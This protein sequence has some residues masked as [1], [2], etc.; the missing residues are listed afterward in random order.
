MEVRVNPNRVL[1]SREAQQEKEI[2]CCVLA[3]ILSIFIGVFRIIGVDSQTYQA[4]AHFWV[5]GLF[6]AGYTNRTSDIFSA[7]NS[8]Y[9]YPYLLWMAWILTGLEAVCFI[10]TRVFD[11]PLPSYRG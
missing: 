6:F 10:C 7:V 11:L 1:R 8:K 2:L 4:L 9:R 3:I 5:G